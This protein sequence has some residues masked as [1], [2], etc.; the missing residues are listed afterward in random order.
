MNAM[1]RMR[2]NVTRVIRSRRLICTFMKANVSRNV[3]RGTMKRR[4]Q[5]RK[6]R[7]VYLA[8]RHALLAGIQRLSV[9]LA[10]RNSYCSKMSIHAM[11]R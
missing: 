2:H 3:Q 1:K 8:K 6:K 10:L 5:L 7:L 11:L 4:Q 9:C